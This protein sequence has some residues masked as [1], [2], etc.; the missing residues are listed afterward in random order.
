[1]YFICYV[2]RTRDGEWVFANKTLINTHPLQWLAHT[3]KSDPNINC[4]LVSWQKLS[5]EE[6]SFGEPFTNE[7]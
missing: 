7:H 2:W 5:A 1:M 3:R 4:R 6:S